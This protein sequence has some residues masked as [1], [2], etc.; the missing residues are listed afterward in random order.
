M[1]ERKQE[2]RGG[3]SAITIACA[4]LLVLLPVLYVLSAGPATWL[5]YHGY[6]SGKA[7]EVLFAPLVWACDHCNPL[8]EF[9]GWYE[10]FFMPDDPA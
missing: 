7:I 2:N 10:T 9:V 6:L 8:Y 3:C 4:C 1:E 5:Y